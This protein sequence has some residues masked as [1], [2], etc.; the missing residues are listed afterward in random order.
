MWKKLTSLS[1]FITFVIQIIF[2]EDTKRLLVAVGLFHAYIHFPFFCLNAAW[3]NGSLSGRSPFFQRKL[4]EKSQIYWKCI[5][6][7]ATN[8][9]TKRLKLINLKTPPHC[10]LPGEWLGPWFFFELMPC[11]LETQTVIKT[12]CLWLA[13]PTTEWVKVKSLCLPKHNPNK[14]HKKTPRKLGETLRFQ[15]KN[16]QA[17][18]YSFAMS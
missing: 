3:L 16:L 10:S 7:K 14:Q 12:Y 5:P 4:S 1:K 8:P 18:Q 2:P 9:K 15:K 6:S 17:A 13:I 11:A